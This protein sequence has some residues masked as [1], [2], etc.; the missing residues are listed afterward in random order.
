MQMNAQHMESNDKDMENGDNSNE[1]EGTKSMSQ[2]LGGESGNSMGGKR[3]VS[4][5]LV[6]FLKWS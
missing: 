3:Y 4:S 6:K 5:Q 2:S 1:E